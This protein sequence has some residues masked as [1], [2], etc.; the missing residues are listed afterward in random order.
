MTVASTRDTKMTVDDVVLT[1]YKMAGLMDA[2]AT[3]SEGDNA[4]RLAY[5]RI[6]LD[7]IVKEMGAGYRPAKHVVSEYLQLVTDQQA[8][9]LDEGIIDVVGDAK[10][11]YAD[12]AATPSAAD[13][14]I[15][16]KQVNRS[17]FY[18]Q[19]DHAS[20]G[21][22]RFFFADRGGDDYQITVYVYQRPSEA[23]VLHMNVHK[24]A[25]DSTDGSATIDLDSAYNQY[26]LHQLGGQLLMGSNHERAAVFLASA[27]M[28]KPKA[29]ETG[30]DHAPTPVDIQLRG[31]QRR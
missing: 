18:L 8:Y 17:Q 11:I 27:E 7:S 3:G 30:A 15:I 16:V 28:L 22:P 2:S 9:T 4:A 13:S 25:A 21:H 6:L 12:D 23:G 29:I 1:A 26:L 10:Y 19:T 24:S 31:A 14:E 5:G 20:S